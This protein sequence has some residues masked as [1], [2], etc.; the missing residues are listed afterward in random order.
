MFVIHYNNTVCQRYVSSFQRSIKTQADNKVIDQ[1]RSVTLGF[2][3]KRSLVQADA[4]IPQT[5][6]SR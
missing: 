6:Q 2:L 1:Y 4:K 5:F 3:T